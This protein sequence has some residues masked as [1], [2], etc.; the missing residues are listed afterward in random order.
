[1]SSTRSLP[2]SGDHRM[3]KKQQ[4]KKSAKVADANRDVCFVICPF[5]G[6]HDRYSKEIFYPAVEDA[7][8]KP[9]R[10]DDIFGPSPI[11]SDVWRSVKRAKIVLA[12][13]TGRNPNVLYELGLA[14]AIQR[15]VVMVTQN[16]GDVPFDL[17]ALRVIVYEQQ[18]PNWGTALQREIT[19]SL[20]EVVASPERFV[21]ATFLE[22]SP[23][24]TSG[25]VEPQEKRILQLEQQVASMQR[26][27]QS[28][29]ALATWATSRAAPFRVWSIPPSVQREALEQEL[30]LRL[31][32]PSSG[33]ATIVEPIVPAAKSEPKEK[34]KKD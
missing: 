12:D 8:L 28:P 2:L 31:S 13:L 33:Q 29:S 32:E 22:Q 21:P 5:G 10:A 19:K 30:M 7:G 14:H 6:W 16:M 1:M 27:L 15:P 26:P 25:T 11:V 20:R 24:R 17:R 4:Q 3:A 23:R 9:L 18:A 34:E